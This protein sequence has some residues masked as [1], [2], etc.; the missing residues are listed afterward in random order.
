[1]KKEKRTAWWSAAVILVVACSLEGPGAVAASGMEGAPEATESREGTSK[2]QKQPRRPGLSHCIWSTEALLDSA[3]VAADD[4]GLKSEH[5][6]VVSKTDRRLMLFRDG[7]LRQGDRGG[8]APSC[9]R[10]GLASGPTGS[11]P[12]GH[13][14][15]QGDLRT[16][17]GWYRTSDKPHSSF[18]AAI[19]VHYPNVRDAERGHA[20]GVL[21]AGEL[22]R[23][24][25]A[26]ARDKKPLQN[27]ALGGEILIHGGGGTSDWTLGCIAMNDVDIDDL[28]AALPS[29]MRMDVLILP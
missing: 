5:L 9:W 19:A 25:S 26:L 18:Y 8:D 3:L 6:I 2:G 14:L 22:A 11:A 20:D 17:E 23:I 15:R 13:K 10:I 27:T 4:A 28:R 12:L 1:M 24:K 7:V 21:S 16:P 29:G